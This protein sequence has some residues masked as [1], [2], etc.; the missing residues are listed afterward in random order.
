MDE[1][2]VRYSKLSMITATNRLSICSK[3]KIAA[4]KKTVHKHVHMPI[5]C[6]R[7]DQEGAEEDE[8][9]KVAVGKVGATAS[10]MVW[11]HGERGNGGIWLTFLTWQTREHNLLPG[12]PRG[13]PGRGWTWMLVADMT[14][15]TSTEQRGQ[16][17]PGQTYLKSSMRALKKV[18]KLLCW[19]MW[20][21]S[22]S[23]M[24]PNTCR[25]K[26]GEIEW[27]HWFVLTIW[28]SL[29]VKNHHEI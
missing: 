19:L 25:Y 22:F 28:P 2:R 15:K 13:A 23:L 3:R 29:L 12:L 7:P 24:F 16:C 5:A 4:D 6:S 14:L 18:L 27:K 8:G 9:D 17:I 10:F 26:G 21:S 11:R 1:S 20:L